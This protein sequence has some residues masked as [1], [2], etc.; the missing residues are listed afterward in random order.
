MTKR[1]KATLPNLC[2]AVKR[3]RE[4]YGD[5]QDRFALRVNL[6]PMTV[7]RFERGK[8][9]PSDM[10]VLMRLADAARAKDL[11]DDADELEQA[12]AA[13]R[14]AAKIED[15]KGSLGPG[16][17][18]W[19]MQI[20]SLQEWRLAHMAVIALRHYPEIAAA[21]EREG[22]AALALVDEAIRQYAEQPIAS[23]LGF[24]NQLEQRLIT[25]VKQ[26]ELERFKEKRNE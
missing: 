22:G 3:I 4:A 24:H 6:A 2:R 12:A 23:G 9:V 25:L 7:S 16:S 11:T 17:G 21:L 18:L 13:T 20:V 5:T 10:H 15:L 1:Q 14:A 8:L 26:R 19:P